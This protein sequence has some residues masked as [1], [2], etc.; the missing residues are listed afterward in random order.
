[1]DIS[2]LKMMEFS[3]MSTFNHYSKWQYAI[4]FFTTDFYY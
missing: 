2:M 1:M 4:Y 3:L